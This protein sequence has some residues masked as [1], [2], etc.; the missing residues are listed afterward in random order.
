MTFE[1][2]LEVDLSLLES[3]VS[4]RRAPV[5]TGCQV[6]LRYSGRDWDAALE[7]HGREFLFPG[8]AARVTVGLRSPAEHAG[9][10]ATGD[11]ISLLDGERMIAVGRIARVLGESG[12]ASGG[13]G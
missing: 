7:L 10:L 9:R 6:R 12:G 8:E 13:P 1:R 4:G 3:R 2:H 11:E 5:F